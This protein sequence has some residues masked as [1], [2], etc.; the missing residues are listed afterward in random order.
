MG[1]FIFSTSRITLALFMY[2]ATSEST[3]YT[4]SRQFGASGGSL[5]PGLT[6]SVDLLSKMRPHLQEWMHCRPKSHWHWIHYGNLIFVI[7]P[8]PNIFA[9]TSIYTVELWTICPIPAGPSIT[10]FWDVGGG[11]CWWWRGWCCSCV[12]PWA[13]PYAL[14]QRLIK[15][16]SSRTSP[17][18]TLYIKQ[19]L[20][21]KL[22]M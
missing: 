12:S 2:L 13:G 3:W 15:K 10:V 8:Y 11:C 14:V 20:V 21:M 16:C 17:K 6:S 5:H 7:M 22:S 1:E 4:G 19:N 18:T 9:T